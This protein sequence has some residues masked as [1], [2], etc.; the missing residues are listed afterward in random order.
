MLLIKSQ[1]DYA[2]TLIHWWILWGRLSVK[3]SKPPTLWSHP[4]PLKLTPQWG[5][6]HGSSDPSEFIA[7]SDTNH[8][9]SK[10]PEDV[11]CISSVAFHFVGERNINS[12]CV[13][14][15][16]VFDPLMPRLSASWYSKVSSNLTSDLPHSHKRQIMCHVQGLG[17]EHIE[18]SLARTWDWH[19]GASCEVWVIFMG[20]F[21]L[22]E[23]HSGKG[24]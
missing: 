16:V 21:C 19:C 11:F 15:A 9:R 8:S 23:L 7:S 6:L 24:S 5:R 3:V 2:P 14:T 13:Y 4:R 12:L 18:L 17:L 20:V 10:I 22:N 1:P